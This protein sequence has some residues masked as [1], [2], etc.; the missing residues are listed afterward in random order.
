MTICF[1]RRNKRLWEAH[2]VDGLYQLA[3][4]DYCNLSRDE[5]HVKW[6][7]ISDKLLDNMVELDGERSP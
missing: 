3:S 1:N 6:G 5:A 2:K 4:A 7:H